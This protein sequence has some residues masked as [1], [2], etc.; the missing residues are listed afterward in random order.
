VSDSSSISTIPVSFTI[1]VAEKLTKINYRLWHAQIL[2]AIREAQLEDLLTGADE[3]SAKT[4]SVKT[5]DT[6]TQK[7][8]PDYVRW[9][10]HDQALLGYL[11]SSLTQEI[12]MGVTTLTSHYVRNS[13]RRH[14]SETHV[15]AIVSDLEK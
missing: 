3:K 13:N 8:N 9:V 12:L 4:I 14:R 2:P 7:A 11:L 6:V 5:G 1:P 15:K 10:T